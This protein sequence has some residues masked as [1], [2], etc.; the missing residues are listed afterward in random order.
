MANERV[1]QNLAIYV[2]ANTLALVTGS[3][4][5][6]LATSNGAGGVSVDDTDIFWSGQGLVDTKAQLI[7]RDVSIVVAGLTVRPSTLDTLLGITAS[8]TASVHN[9]AGNTATARR[10]LNTTEKIYFRLGLRYTDSDDDDAEEWYSPRTQ[11]V[12]SL[13]FAQDKENWDTQEITFKCFGPA[14]GDGT[15][16]EHLDQT[17]P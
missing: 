8:A 3:A 13:P 7:K 14:S 10:I 9:A 6:L 4:T 11:F 1:T 2:A 15:L 12:G 16:I 17:S 5:Q